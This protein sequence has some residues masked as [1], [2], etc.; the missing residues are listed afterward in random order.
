MTTEHIDFML[1]KIPRAAFVKIEEIAGARGL[2]RLG[3]QLLHHRRGVRHFR[4]AGDVLTPQE[5]AQKDR[6]TGIALMCGAVLLFACSDASA[7]YLNGHMDTIQVVWARYMSAFV[8]ALFMFQ[9][10]RRPQV[11]RTGRPWLQLGRS[12]LLLVS[13]ALNF[14]ALRYL[15]LDQASRSS[16]APR[17]SSRRSAGRCSANG[18]AGGAG[19]R[20]ASAFS[21]CCW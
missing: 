1:S 7:K 9:P 19:P 3:R 4:R 2:V 18:S 17:S 6:L 8:L 11:M 20:S 5:Q 13:T 10:I 14:V 15:Q 16:S 12:T 21:A